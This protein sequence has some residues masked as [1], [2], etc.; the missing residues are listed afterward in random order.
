MRAIRSVSVGVFL[1]V[2]LMA[3]V[4]SAQQATIVGVITDESKAVL[5]GVTVTVSDM[6]KGTQV[7]AVTDARGEY[8]VLQLTPGEY[9]VQ[10]ELGGFAT[11]VQE[12][13]TLLVGQNISIPIV[14]K[15]AT[16]SETLTV[17]GQSPLVDTR[18]TQVSGNVNPT[19]MQE[20]PLLGRNW[21][22]LAKMVPGMTA[23]VIS[24]SNPGVNANNWAM[25][26]DGQAVGNKTSQGLGQPKFSREAIAEYQIVTNL[27]DVTQGGSTGVQLQAITKSGTNALSGSGYG[28][29]RDD[30]LNA[31][32]A[33][34]KTVLPYHD[35]QWGATLGGPIVKDK[36]HYF[37]AFEYERTPLSIYNTVQALGQST[38]I[39]NTQLTKSLLLR[40]DDQLTTNDRLSVRGTWSAYADPFYLSSPSNTHP[41]QASDATQ[42]SFNVLGTWSKVVSTSAVQEVKVGLKHY[43]FAYVPLITDMASPELVFPGLTVGPVNWM[44][45]WHAQD[46]V[47]A[48]YD[49]NLHRGSHDFKL[50]GE[51]TNARMWDD[52]H[53]LGRGQM[54]FTSLPLDIARRI[55]ASEAMNPAAWDLTGLNPIA[56]RFN[57]NYPKTDFEWVTP[58]PQFALWIGD[59]WR[60][61]NSLTI[62]YGMRYTN[63]WGGATAP[64]I[65][66]NSIPI[67]Q[68]ATANTPGANIPYLAPGDFGYKVGVH[69]NL[70]FGP[71]GGFAWNVG[72]G[73]D[74]VIRGGT[75]L[76]YTVYEKA[77][78]K[79][80]IL[81]SNLF[82]A[83][84]NNNGTN[85]NFVGNPTNG[86]DSYDEAILLKGIPQ[87]GAMV[88]G[89]LK[90]PMS[91]QSGL[92][93][94]KQIGPRASISADMVYRKTLREL[95]TISPNLY[96]DPVTG[97]NVNPSKGVPNADWGQISN[98]VSSGYG[99]YAAL[100]TSFTRRVSNHVEG[101]ASYTLMFDYKDTAS[102]A[103]NPF[104]YLDGEY[105]TS[106][107]FQRNTLRAWANYDL[108]WDL[109]VSGTYAYGSG[110]RYA[111]LIASNPYGGTVNN[112]LN[113]G[114][115]GIAAPAI[116]VPAAMLDRWLGPAVIGS[117]VVIPRDALQGTP[118]NRVD[119][120][121]TKTIRLGNSLRASLMA[122][123]FN[124][125]NYANYTA[126]NTQLS[127]TSAATTSRFGLPTAAD[128]SRQAQF[129]FR[130]TF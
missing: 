87:S 73:N 11:V 77:N 62:N 74:L 70:D 120:R 127:A 54:T 91:W 83:Q 102:T 20:V 81:T 2:A 101:G 52:Y 66:P 51:Y 50:G 71:Q 63:Y 98:R 82:S 8:R 37:F 6:A 116:T 27:Y 93:F 119:L 23:N 34:S 69:D 48:R 129:G 76:Y 113:L 124:V 64:G 42:G 19:Q 16:L 107:S 29:F 26:L 75:G 21:L 78:T 5:P 90:M 33:V 14:L 3:G 103:S 115:N 67:T 43:S 36:L 30:S 22:E 46:Y 94:S 109:A 125:F 59:T 28:F 88:N 105:A 123:V 53:V 85:P 126:F 35:D 7:V 55:P 72:G 44:P 25:N 114:A 10:A 18:S 79:N 40:V 57:I 41:S 4:A 12:K 38:T 111:A 130:V 100:Q 99:E 86:V 106:Q 84:F 110:N 61:S 1:F 89:E 80:Q 104:D 47:S 118:Y 45:Q 95:Q 112:R 31:A 121:L 60:T 58:D 32:D 128:V 65:T 17:T 68:Y 15:V 122:E 39:P 97:Y 92:G 49:L 24:T 96:Y 56:Q 13:I 117:G 108:P 9:K